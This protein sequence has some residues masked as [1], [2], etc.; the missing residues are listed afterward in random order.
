MSDLADASSASPPAFYECGKIFQQ[1]FGQAPDACLVVI[2]S[3]VL[4]LLTL[5]DILIFTIQIVYI[6][7]A[8]RENK[9]G[10]RRVICGYEEIGQVGRPVVGH[11]KA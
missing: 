10:Q 4:S 3:C 5:C 9:R 6:Q 1:A 8:E 2:N 11:W 7:N